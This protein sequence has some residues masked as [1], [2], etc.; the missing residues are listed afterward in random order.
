M[1]TILHSALKYLSLQ[2]ITRW[3]F[4][5]IILLHII[6]MPILGC[7]P[8]VSS[9]TKISTSPVSGKFAKGI[10]LEALELITD[11]LAKKLR[12]EDTMPDIQMV[13]AIDSDIPDTPDERNRQQAIHRKAVAGHVCSRPIY[14]IAEVQN[15]I[16]QSQLSTLSRRNNQPVGGGR[17]VLHKAGAA[18]VFFSSLYDIIRWAHQFHRGV[19]VP[20]ASAGETTEP[21]ISARKEIARFK[22]CS[23]ET[24][25]L[26]TIGDTKAT[27]RMKGAYVEIHR[28]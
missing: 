5:V 20:L 6:M 8:N 9:T 7:L 1:K 25:H 28:I 15:S 12:G 17:V 23:K 16:A 21:V 22:S 2:Q 18:G 14:M 3:N 24:R 27:M 4:G 13:P 19:I 26:G 11:S 10:D